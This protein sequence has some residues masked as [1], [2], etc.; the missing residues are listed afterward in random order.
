MDEL[1]YQVDLLNAMNQR[2]TNDEKMYRLLCNTSSNA[3]LYVN[4]GDNVVRTLG[5]W[6]FFFPD[7]VIKDMKDL[8]KLYSQVEDKY[9][10]PLK[11][12]I[13]L[14]KKEMNSDSGIVRLKD[15]RT[16]VE[17]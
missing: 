14:E 16:W 13:F 6:D 2:L 5:S 15:E 3:F 10:L 17:C 11:N 8:A 7:V 4:F 9:V 1:R 12:L